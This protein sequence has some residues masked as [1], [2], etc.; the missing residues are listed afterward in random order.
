MKYVLLV[1]AILVSGCSTTSQFNNTPVASSEF[2]KPLESIR[3][4]YSDVSLYEET[5]FLGMGK[6]KGDY[7]NLVEKWGEPDRAKKRWKEKLLGLLGGAAIFALPGGAPLETILLIGAIFPHP[8]ENNTWVKGE[9]EV[10]A[11]THKIPHFGY[12]KVV[13]KWEWNELAEEAQAQD[14]LAAKSSEGVQ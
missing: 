13:S 12:K 6:G 8:N 14:V 3:T 9:Y 11:V 10:T 4:E 5:A 1:L 2:T 7:N